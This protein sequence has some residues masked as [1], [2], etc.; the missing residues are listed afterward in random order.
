MW[1]IYYYLVK[2]SHKAI[3]HRLYLKCLYCKIFLDQLNS[4]VKPRTNIG[5]VGKPCLQ[6][7]DHTNTPKKVCEIIYPQWISLNKIGIIWGYSTFSNFFCNQKWQLS[8]LFWRYQIPITDTYVC[9]KKKYNT[10]ESSQSNPYLR[11]RKISISE[12]WREIWWFTIN[13][14]D[15]R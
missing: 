14:M 1:N 12:K 7:Y 3:R 4:P 8:I 5:M 10:E 13:C 9:Y 15:K 6:L 2:L 11:L